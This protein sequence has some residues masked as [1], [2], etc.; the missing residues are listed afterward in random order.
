MSDKE[1]KDK[2]AER[3]VNERG[4]EVMRERQEKERWD[5]KRSEMRDE[6]ERDRQEPDGVVHL[7][8]LP[9]RSHLTPFT[10]PSLR[11]VRSE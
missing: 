8:S 6:N 11:S 2:G 5:R 1:M 10:L 3:Y 9:L 7:R 4:S